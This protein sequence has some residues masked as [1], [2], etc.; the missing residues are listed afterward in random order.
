MITEVPQRWLTVKQAARYIGKSRSE[1][2]A[3]VARREIP[4]Y[5]AGGS[6]SIRIDITE[7][8]QWVRTNDANLRY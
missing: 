7:L 4:S 1:T 8:D 3:L 5:R 2:Y 6:Q